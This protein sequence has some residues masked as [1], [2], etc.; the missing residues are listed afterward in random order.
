MTFKFSVVIPLYNKSQYI[1]RAINSILAQNYPVDEII[2]VDDGSTDDSLIKIRKLN[3]PLIQI[4]EQEN[5][6]VSI[7]RNTGIK[8]CRNEYILLLDAD[9]YWL[10]TFTSE[11][12]KL[13]KTYPDAGMLACNY[14]FKT[15]EKIIPANLKGIPEKS[16]LIPN[17]FASCVKADLPITASSVALRKSVFNSIG[18]FPVGMKMGEDQ[19]VWSRISYRYPIAFSNT[20]A[21]YYDKAVADSASKTHLIT[22]L[23]PHIKFW[24]QDLNE[25]RI[26]THMIS[27]LTKLLHFSALYCVKNNL[28]LNNR[29][30]AR[31]LLFNEKLI[32][33][34]IYWVISIA[35]TYTPTFILKRVL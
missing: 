12:K 11:I 5:Q 26:P 29:K 10:N 32:F 33:R 8:K 17:Y 31:E 22:N 20:I 23:A 4:I 25:N 7:A 13:A 21:V 3:S 27:S 19:L 30:A 2:I 34:D 1:I 14:A 35:L 18:G 24:Q 9:D 15:K 16:G 6:G 28:K